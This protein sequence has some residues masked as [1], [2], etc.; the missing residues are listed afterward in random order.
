MYDYGLSTLEQ[1][2]LTAKTA[3]R[4]RGALICHTEKGL[5]I[6]REFHGSEKKL[7]KQQE[8]LLT[9]QENGLSVDSFLENQEGSLVSRDKDEIPFTLQ[10]WYDGREC[11]TKSRDDIQ[12]SV[13]T[14]AKLH[15][16]MRLSLVEDYEE[17]S[18][19]DEYVRHNQEI[20]K[21]RKFIRKKGPS[22]PF[23]K[24]FLASVE[25]FLK[26]GEEALAMLGDSSYDTLREQSLSSGCICHGEYNQHNVLMVRG[27]TAVT[28]FGHWGFDVQMADLYRFMRKV[29]EKYNWDLRLAQEMLNS[30]HQERPISILEW[31]NLKVRF[32]Y[33]EKYWKLANYYYS[34]NKAWISE[35]NIEKL[36]ILVKQKDIWGDFP[37]KCFGRY[38][39]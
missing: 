36:K 14:L 17:K 22:S 26:K 24:D 39:F 12:K 4:T 32:T 1:Y 18:L 7:Q 2:G 21:I 20:R 37:E 25:W 34:H 16:V 11:D 35:K 10:H 30:Y 29:L 27:G 9:L 8:L 28:N 3:S 33:P 19:K 31:Q 13:R 15:K 5:L 6:L 23:E 38:P